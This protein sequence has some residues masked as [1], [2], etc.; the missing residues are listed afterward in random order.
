VGTQ[1]NGTPYNLVLQDPTVNYPAPPH[2]QAA[3]LNELATGKMRWQVT[4]G[5]LAYYTQSQLPYY[6]SLATTYGLADNHFSTV[7]G[8]SLPNH[9]YLVAASANEVTDVGTVQPGSSTDPGTRIGWTNSWI[10]GAKHGGSSLPYTY[11]GTRVSTNALDGSWYYGGTC[12]NHPSTSCT[13][14]C[15][16]GKKCPNIFDTSD[17]GTACTTDP[18]C[19]ALGDTCSTAQTIGGTSGSPCLVLTTVFDQIESVLGSGPNSWGYYSLNTQWNGAAYFQNI[20]FDNARWNTHIHQDTQFDTDVGVCTGMCSNNHAMACTIDAQCGSGSCIDSDGTPPGSQMCNLPKVT[21][22]SSTAANASDHDQDGPLLTGEFWTLDRLGAFFRSPYVYNHSILFLT[23][24]DWGGYYDH[25]PPPV[26]D[27]IP[28]LGFRVP[29][30]CVG[31]YCRNRI[32]HTQFEF[33][34]VLK[35]LEGVFG[36]PAINARDAGATDACAGTG[37]LASNTDGMVNLSQHPI[38]AIGQSLDP[39]TTLVQ[40]SLNPSTYQQQ[41]TFTANVTSTS[42]M[43]TGTVTFLDGGSSIGSN[44]LSQGSASIGRSDLLGGLHSITASYGGDPTFAPSTSSPVSQAV[45]PAASTTTL[46]SSADPS[47]LGQTVTF[48]ATVTGGGVTATG[49]VT[50]YDGAASLGVSTVTNGQASLGTSALAIGT[51]SMSASYG[52]DSNYKSSASPSLVQTIAATTST[53][54]LT[55]SLNPSTYNRSVTFAASVTSA[56]GTP[57]GSVTFKDGANAL[58]TSALINGTATLNN[59]SLTAGLHSIT[60]V[61][62]GDSNSGGST[63]APLTQTVNQATTSTALA[64]SLDPSSANQAV[65]FTATVSSQFGGAVAGS[66]TFSQGTTALSTVPLTNGQAS[67]A[68]PFSAAGTFSITATFNGDSNNQGSTSPSLT[69]TVN[70]ATSSTTLASGLNPS[71]ANQPVTFTANVTSQYGAAV[72]GSVTFKQGTSTLAIVSLTNGQASYAATFAAAGSLSITAVYSGDSNNQGSTSASLTQ[73]VNQARSST[74]LASGLNPSSANQPVTFT[75]NVTSQ[76]GAAVTGSVTFKQGTSTLATVSLTNGQASYATTFA[77]TGTFSVTAVYSGDSNNQGS[78]SASLT[79]TVNQATTTTTLISALN[80]SSANQLVSFTASVTSQYGAGV[81]GSITFKQGTTALSTVSL[82]N[83]QASYATPFATAG[84]FSITGVYSGDSNNQ[85]STSAPLTQTVNQAITSTTVVSSFNPAVAG[86]SVTFNST[87]T[88]QYGE[89]VTG[90]VTFKQGGAALSTALLIS[91]KA[92]YTTSFNAGTFSVTATYSGDNND[93]SST[94]APLAL[95]VNQATTATALTSNLNPSYVN[96]SVIFTASVVSQFGGTVTGTATFK[97][98]TSTLATVPL[99]LG[100]A[101][102]ATS[103]STAATRSITATYSGD[104]NNLVSTSATLSQVVKAL[105]ALTTTNLT[106]S[107]NPSFFGQP[108]TFTASVTSPYGPIPDG[109]LVNFF[110][111]GT[112][113]G[114][115]P[116]TNGVATFTTSSLTV[117]SPVIKATFVGDATFASSSKSITQAVKLDPTTTAVRSSLNPAN[118]GQSVTFTATVT[119]TYGPIPNGELVT[120][121]DGTTTLGSS[122]LTGGVATLATS[123]LTVATHVIKAT[124]PGDATFATS[125]RSLTQVVK[126]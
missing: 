103:Y 110:D 96:Q 83:G 12:T 99:T 109:H 37:T 49:S 62:S 126:Q 84:T 93:Q 21:Y 44:T 59:S 111:G 81:T 8:F 90:S 61:Y 119:S 79:Q 47:A 78:T 123:S 33:A 74:T 124:Y 91:G 63:S 113:L 57:T 82:A 13:C 105:P 118:S 102:Y 88:S 55:S 22:L 66:V 69:Q 70:Q 60:A 52:G 67:Y 107:V 41:V 94:S 80:P 24:D 76:Y 14:H 54:T 51:H 4:S 64:S 36:L 19:T 122:S 95:T 75:A 10:C 53:T 87:V 85:G 98:G 92:S 1:A 71:S 58:G 72:T 46:Q 50:F 18:G 48:T 42:G 11:P 65:T 43:P 29:L 120:F 108:V 6:Y 27:H 89:A 125:T 117:G 40:S 5:G 114:S 32:T 7:G 100:Q 116:M 9:A 2:S 34:S 25:V 68:T 39:T 30:I 106:S 17:G 23:W 104:S 121:F 35:C 31:P 97:Q 3:F 56:A 115:A 101:S 86:Q 112:S 38:P 45:N 20:Y 77:A 28:T 15:A 73:T 26:E 16:P